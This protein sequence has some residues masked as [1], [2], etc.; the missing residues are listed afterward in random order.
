ML[1]DSK[2]ISSYHKITSPKYMA[3]K[4][5]E[6]ISPTTS[7]PTADIRDACKVLI[8]SLK[9]YLKRQFW[10][11]P[12]CITSEMWRYC[13]MQSGRRTLEVDKKAQTRR[14]QSRRYRKKS[15]NSERLREH[16]S[17][18][19]CNRDCQHK[20]GEKNVEKVFLVSYFKDRLA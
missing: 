13:S 14:R 6:C 17:M 19:F 2:C 18:L 20:R 5:R 12:M 4:M 9:M 15:I 3:S 8:A 1:I 10:N 7:T 11:F 16:K